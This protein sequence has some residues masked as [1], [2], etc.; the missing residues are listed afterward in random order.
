[1]SSDDRASK[2]APSD[3]E[4]AVAQAFSTAAGRMVL[5]WLRL[6]TIERTMA[7]DVS[8][9]QLRHIE[10]QRDLVRKLENMV[11]RM[12]GGS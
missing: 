12:H 11:R 5:G 1:M 6:Q 3:I 4:V 10:G 9:A 2:V 8:E 7:P